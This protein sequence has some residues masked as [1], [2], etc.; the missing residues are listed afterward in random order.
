MSPC[1]AQSEGLRAAA[2]GRC[3]CARPHGGCVGRPRRR[4]DAASQLCR[5]GVALATER[6]QVPCVSGVVFAC[7][8]MG[9]AAATVVSLAV[10]TW[11]P[12]G[13]VPALGWRLAFAI[14]GLG[15]LLS[16]ALRRSVEESPEFARMKELASR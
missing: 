10:R 14:G 16:L 6:R 4:G 1:R 13:L 9:V 12:P 5:A 3:A 8:T 2:D 15:G 7:V 11:L